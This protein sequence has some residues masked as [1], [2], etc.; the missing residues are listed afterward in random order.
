MYGFSYVA[1][2][3][4]R[5]ERAKLLFAIKVTSTSRAYYRLSNVIAVFGPVPTEA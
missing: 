5:W 2:S 4:R 3:Y 1:E